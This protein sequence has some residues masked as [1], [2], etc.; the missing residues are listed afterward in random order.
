MSEEKVGYASFRGIRQNK[1][2]AE[3]SSSKKVLE[4]SRRGREGPY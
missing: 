1:E 4:Q 2:A 3:A